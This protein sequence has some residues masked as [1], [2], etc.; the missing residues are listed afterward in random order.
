VSSFHPPAPTSTVTAQPS[1]KQIKFITVQHHLVQTRR[2][3][4]HLGIDIK[5]LLVAPATSFL[6]ILWSPGVDSIEGYVDPTSTD[7]RRGPL[8]RLSS[9]LGT[10]H[11]HIADEFV[12]VATAVS[13]VIRSMDHFVIQSSL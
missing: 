13:V 12:F 2:P 5:P 8:I 11:Q 10:K 6:L 3:C 9:P 4:L 1:S 7:A